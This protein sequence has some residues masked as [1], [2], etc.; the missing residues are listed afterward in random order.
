MGV[1]DEGAVLT[2]FAYHLQVE[3]IAMVLGL[4]K[5]SQ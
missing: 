2:L 3:E 1:H 5:E 4:T